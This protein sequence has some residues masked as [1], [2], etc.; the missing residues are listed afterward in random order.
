MKRF[1]ILLVSISFP[2]VSVK[3]GIKNK[4]IISNMFNACVEQDD[5]PN[6]VGYQYSYCG[7]FVNKVSKGMTTRELVEVDL[8]IQSEENPQKQSQAVLANKKMKEFIVD[9]VSSTFDE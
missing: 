4:S 2:F 8:S 5:Y 9:C 7:C 1:L 6:G 3:A